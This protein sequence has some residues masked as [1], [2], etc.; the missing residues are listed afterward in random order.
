VRDRTCRY[1]GKLATGLAFIGTDRYCH[2]DED[3]PPT[4]YEKA[5]LNERILNKHAATFAAL[6]KK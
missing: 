6:A 3:V 4:C 5:Q 2:G 1:C